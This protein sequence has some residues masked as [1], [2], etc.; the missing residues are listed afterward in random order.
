M[1][2]LTGV[3]RFDDVEVFEAADPYPGPASIE[4]PAQALLNRLTYLYGSF[5]DAWHDLDVETTAPSSSTF[6]TGIDLRNTIAPGDPIRWLDAEGVDPLDTSG[7]LGGYDGL[8]GLEP[9]ILD[10]RGRLWAEVTFDG[11][12]QSVK[13]YSDEAKTAQVGETDP[14]DSIGTYAVTGSNG[15]GLAGTLDFDALPLSPCVVDFFV[16]FFRWG[17]VDAITDTTI[18]VRGAPASTG[19]GN[20]RSASQGH[21]AR[22]AMLGAS[23]AGDFAATAGTA[24]LADIAKHPVRWEGSNARLI[25]LRV[26]AGSHSGTSPIVNVSV[27]GSVVCT[28]GSGDGLTI[29]APTTFFSTGVDIDMETYAVEYGDDIEITTTQGDGGGGD[30]DLAALMLLVL[31]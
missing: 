22:I 4:V 15:S 19:S 23:V 10:Q 9:A 28:A 21:R 24:L 6:T 11:T 17:V 1:K 20:I 5:L 29:S 27:D 16:D 13:L 18:T 25:G 2:T 8:T 26:W 7:L 14:H 30:S 3:Q 31:E 12:D